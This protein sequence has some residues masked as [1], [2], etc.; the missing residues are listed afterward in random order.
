MLTREMILGADDLPKQEVAV[1]EWGGS[2]YVRALT[3]AERVQ[4]ER[5]VFAATD[6]D[7]ATVMAQLVALCTVDEQGNRLF[8][9]EDVEALNRKNSRCLNKVASAAIMFNALSAEGVEEAGND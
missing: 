2:V 1:P 5:V 4:F 9:A 7:E 6:E 8:T 3:G